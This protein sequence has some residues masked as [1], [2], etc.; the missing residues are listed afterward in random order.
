MEQHT[1]SL[2]R[3]KQT[4]GETTEDGPGAAVMKIIE[5]PLYKVKWYHEV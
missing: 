5:I 3:W 1:E 4:A 2:E